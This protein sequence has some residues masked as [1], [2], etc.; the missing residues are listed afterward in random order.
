MIGPMARTAALGFFVALALALFAAP[1]N[2]GRAAPASG[3]AQVWLAYGHDGQLTNFVRFPGLTPATAHRLREVWTK[4]LDGPVIASP[5]YVSGGLIGLPSSTHIVIAATEAG[6]V[7]ALR[8]SNGAVRW[9][10]TFG[11]VTPAALCGTWGISSTG[12]ID[13]RRRVLYVISADGW[14][15]ALDLG[16]GAEKAGW[17]ISITADHADGEYVWGGLRLLRDTLYVP[18]ASYCDEP[19]SD[20]VRANGRLVAVDVNLAAQI[21]VF[22]TVPGDGNLGGIWGWGGVSVDQGTDALH[23]HRKFVCV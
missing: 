13:L 10:R 5:L 9:K 12:A 8:P 18:V 7:Y 21:A 14:L 20:G 6:T 22:D 17:P 15:H 1:S 23:G 16:T 2:P 19:G 4:K 3:R 11:V